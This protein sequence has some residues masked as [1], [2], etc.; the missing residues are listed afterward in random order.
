MLSTYFIMPV[1][2]AIKVGR[3]YMMPRI[4][5]LIDQACIVCVILGNLLFRKTE[6]TGIL[7]ITVCHI[8]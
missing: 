4:P 8:N 3:R 5:V 1:V 7:E 6:T 2:L